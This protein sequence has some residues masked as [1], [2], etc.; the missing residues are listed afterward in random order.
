MVR[1]VEEEHRWI[2]AMDDEVIVIL[3]ERNL[4]SYAKDG[5]VRYIASAERVRKYV[6]KEITEEEF[7]E[8]VDLIRKDAI[9]W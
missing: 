5:K 1:V 3:K 4:A 2:V 9:L 7:R 8:M 6:G